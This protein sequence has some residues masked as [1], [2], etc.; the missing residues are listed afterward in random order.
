VLLRHPRAVLLAFAVIV[1][2]LATLGFGVNEKLSPTSLDISNTPASEANELLKKNFGDTALF[3]ILLQ[4]PADEID[5]QGPELVRALRASNPQVTTLSPWDRGSVK[6]LRPAPDKALVITDFHTDIAT[7]TKKSVGELEEILEREIK[8]PVKATQSGFPTLSKALQ[9]ESISASE[10]A[11]LIALPVLLIVL[12]LVFRSPIAAAIPLTFG[13]ITV[14]ISSGVLTIVTNWVGV[15][16]FALTVCTMMG[17]ALGVDYALLMVS[18]FREELA[19]GADPKEAAIRTRHTAGRTTVFAGS[20]LIAAMLVALFVVPGALLSSL[21]A[22]V[23]LVVILSVSVATIAGPAVLTLIGHNVNR[24]RIGKPQS[25]QDES[26]GL[27]TIV[28]AALRRPALVCLVVGA[29]VLALAT[30][31]IG[32]KTGPP[33]AQQLSHNNQARKDA[34]LINRTIAP[35]FDAPFVVVA[36]AEN[37]PITTPDRLD[38]LRRWQ[39]RVAA[40]P[41]V[42]VVIGPEQVSKSVEPLR[43]A[44]NGLLVKKGGPVGNLERLGRNLKRAAKGVAKLREGISEATQGAGLLAEGSDRTEEG[45]LRL[46]SGLST[47]TG[48]SEEAV[49]ALDE[50]AKGAR[51]LE[52]GAKKVTEGQEKVQE[53]AEILHTNL[54]NLEFN[55]RKNQL[56][57]A[58]KLQKNLTEIAHGK[59][60]AVKTPAASAQSSSKTALQ[61]LEGMTVGKSDP[62][63]AAALAAA[64]QASSQSAATLAGIEKLQVELIK[65]A[66]EARE[67]SFW[68]KTGI[69][70]VER[71]VGTAQELVEGEEK[72]VK[73][74]GELAS[75]SGEL[76]EGAETL[77]TESRKLE[78]GL[79]QLGAG[80]ARLAAGISELG[81]GATSLQAGLGEAFNRSHPLQTGTSRMAAR[82]TV[83]ANQARGQTDELR[84]ESPGIF[85]S[86]NFVLAALDGANP[87]L[88]RQATQA[89]D[90]EKGGQAATVTVFSKYDFN[91]PGS[92]ALN[93]T[94]EGEAADLADETG[95]NTGVAGG[96]STLNE[97][98]KVTRERIPL[99]IVAITIATFLILVLILRAIPLA[100]IAVGLNLATV[101]VAFGVLTLLFNVPDNLPLGGHT[102][103]DAVGATMIFGI[104]F[105]LSIDY[106]V[107]LLVRMR[108]RYEE[109]GDNAAAIEFGLEK[110]ARVITGAA[111]IMMAVFIAFAGAPIA[112]VSQLGTGL[113][114]AVLLDATVVRIVFL[115]S[116]MLLLGDRVWWYPRFLDRITPRLNV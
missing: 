77:A 55:L 72:L 24:W 85:N 25:Y 101:G 88:R 30:P 93:K 52:K 68:A 73:A 31:A 10:R 76:A 57:R 27:M 36:E 109:D 40:I 95:L 96:A 98:S 94:L 11:E 49:G 41:G 108:E 2:V 16:A 114:I 62:N 53:G 56:R 74:N 104:V 116:L 29:V 58:R 105:G 34:E 99:I 87:R 13:A 51:K 14:F 35:G 46:A 66:E 22:T 71:E 102:Y 112:N 4:G 84:H 1:V 45:A 64:R 110:T 100:A 37:G 19:G 21:A 89:V 47:A 92:I 23:I 90:L 97:Y 9:D 78:E 83:N 7:A 3:A 5:K 17:L 54:K 65:E 81:E 113:T 44:G 61:L 106:A 115:P 107:F 12:L 63:Y 26:A 91:S 103:V 86:G 79:G 69:K 15:D 75:G 50:F 20:T 48:G 6:Q 82:V 43:E 18:R 8:P 70:E 60:D 39:D 42:Q 59:A 33:S 80:A 111:V 32:L 38:A 67:V 28:G